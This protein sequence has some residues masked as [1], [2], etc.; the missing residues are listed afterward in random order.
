M[1]SQV[2]PFLVCIYSV[3]AITISKGVAAV[4]FGFLSSRNKYKQLGPGEN[5][6]TGGSGRSGVLSSSKHFSVPEHRH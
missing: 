2:V 1:L 4:F 3:G 5:H 6:V